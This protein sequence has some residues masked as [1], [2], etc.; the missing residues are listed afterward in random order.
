MA[1]RLTVEE[2]RINALKKIIDKMFEL[3]GY[4]IVLEDVKSLPPNWYSIYTMSDDEWEKWQEFGKDVLQ[5]D[6]KLSKKTASVEMS[7]LSLN[8]GLKIDNT[9]TLRL[10]KL[11]DILD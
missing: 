11:K 8:Y 9:K 5:K 3:A 6:L 4:Q 10:E 1:K 7:F 2:K